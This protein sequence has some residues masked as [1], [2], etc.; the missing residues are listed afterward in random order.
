[1][2]AKEIAGLITKNISINLG[3]PMGYMNRNMMG[4]S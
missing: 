1:M 4:V 2:I 3:S